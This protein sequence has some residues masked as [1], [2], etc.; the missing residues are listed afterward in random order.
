MNQQRLPQPFYAGMAGEPDAWL[1]LWL[2]CCD[3]QESVGLT[4][5]LHICFAAL[6]RGWLMPLAAAAAP[7]SSQLVWVLLLL[8]GA[9]GEAAAAAPCPSLCYYSKAA[10]VC[11]SEALCF[12]W[13]RQQAPFHDSTLTYAAR[14]PV[15][16][17]LL[18]ST[19]VS[20]I[21]AVTAL[22]FACRRDCRHAIH[23]R[24]CVAGE[25][26]Q[27]VFV[28]MVAL[29]S[30]SAGLMAGR[31]WHEPTA[32]PTPLSHRRGRQAW[33]KDVS[34]L[35]HRSQLDKKVA[36]HVCYAARGSGWLLPLAAAA[37]P[38]SS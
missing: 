25:L 37:A 20:A 18:T 35:I 13:L 14:A 4:V 36:L 27:Q 16:P 11:A 12:F 22:H 17:Q 24:R 6:G 31:D 9:L 3:S 29:E 5:A 23:C 26:S 8:S 30:V 28:G 10:G 7:S 21:G 1:L 2:F 15:Q 32:A 34:T 19:H 38:S 33:C